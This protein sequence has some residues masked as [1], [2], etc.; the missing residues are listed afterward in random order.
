MAQQEIQRY[1][2]HWTDSAFKY[3]RGKWVLWKDVAP[4]IMEVKNQRTTA[5][6]MPCRKNKK[7]VT[8]TV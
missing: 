4:Y 1:S 6:G 5:K 7:R 2:I 3:K 8:A